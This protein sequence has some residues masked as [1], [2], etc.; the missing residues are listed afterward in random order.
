MPPCV[1]LTSYHLQLRLDALHRVLAQ[2]QAQRGS[3]VSVTSTTA[4]AAFTGS[5]G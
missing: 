3:A 1:E 5:P 2:L 4:L